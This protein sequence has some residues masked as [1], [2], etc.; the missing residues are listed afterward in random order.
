[1]SSKQKKGLGISGQSKQMKKIPIL[2]CQP[3]Q[4][5]ACSFSIR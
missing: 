5:P 1:M 4:R 2:D 3:F